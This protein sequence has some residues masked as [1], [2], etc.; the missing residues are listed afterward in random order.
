M[1][2]TNPLRWFAALI[3][4]LIPLSAAAAQTGSLLVK[5]IDHPVC[6][7]QVANAQGELTEEFVESNLPP[8]ITDPVKTAKELQTYVRKHKITGQ[9]ATPIQGEACFE[10]LEEGL[11]LVCSLHTKGEF[12]PFL[13][14]IPTTLNGQTI[15]HVEAK[16]KLDDIPPETEDPDPSETRPSD[17]E[18]DKSGTHTIPQTGTS[19]I[20]KYGLLILGTLITLTGL[21]QVLSGREENS[22]D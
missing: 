1:K 7:Y 6:L 19:V 2:N 21:Y 5:G 17:K 8:A 18:N 20:P 16:P 10:P 12:A 14:S 3:L 4:L 11:Y 13:L 9:K 15:Y 22:Y